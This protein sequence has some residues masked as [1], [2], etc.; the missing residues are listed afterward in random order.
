MRAHKHNVIRLSALGTYL[1]G[2]RY[3]CRCQ[4]IP[5]VIPCVAHV[6]SLRFTLRQRLLT[7]LV[8]LTVDMAT[9]RKPEELAVPDITEDPAERKRVLNVLAQRRYRMSSCSGVAEA[10]F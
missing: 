2:T 6:S 4:D 3:S 7:R 10:Q 1:G 9:K 8:V 5:R